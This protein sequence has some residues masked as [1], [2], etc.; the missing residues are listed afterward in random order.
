MI[1]AL[2]A[3]LLLVGCGDRSVATEPTGVQPT[4]SG[5]IGASVVSETVPLPVGQTRTLWVSGALKRKSRS[6]SQPTWRSS[7]P[8]VARVAAAT[9]GG[10][11]GVVTGVA[12][13]AAYVIARTPTAVDSFLVYVGTGPAALRFTVAG[14]SLTTGDTARVVVLDPKSSASYSSLNPTIASVSPTG[15]V[16]A[17]VA[18]Q[19]R[20]RVVDAFGAR[21]EVTVTVSS[22]VS[23]PPPVGGQRIAAQLTRFAAGSGT[24]LVSSGVPLPPAALRVSDLGT[25]RVLVGGTE[26][27][28]FVAA[29]QGRHVDGSV[30]TILVQFPYAV[31]QGTPVAAEI[32][33]GSS[34]TLADLPA[35]PLNPGLPD[36]VILPS[37]PNFLA[38]TNIVGPTLSVERTS[39]ISPLAAK[40]DVD[41]RPFADLLWNRYGDAWGENYYDRAQIYFAQWVRTGNPE[42]WLRGTRQALGYR[43]GYLEANSY[44]TSPHWSQVDGMALH[45]QLTGD[46]KSRFAVGRIAETL[47]YFRN[48]AGIAGTVDIESRILAR[49]LMAQLWGWRLQARGADA[50]ATSAEIS[51]LVTN[52][53]NLQSTD[54]AWRYPYVCA[55]SRAGLTYMDGMLSEALI[56]TYTYH[57][58]NPAI[59]SA[60]RKSTDYLWSKWDISKQAVAYA[61]D[62]ALN[63]PSQPGN[64]PYPELNN[65]LVN[66]FAWLYAQ[67]GDL[68]VRQKADSVFNGAVRGQ[69]LYGS[70]QF[71]QHYTTSYR[72]FF[73]R[74]AR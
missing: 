14:Y 26:Q 70:K 71:N 41:F 24:V 28:I 67:T 15:L 51:T 12:N 56:Q 35:Q 60:V 47:R 46:E 44:G 50:I 49:T 72:Y 66:S 55:T 58:A 40:Y 7:D 20:I 69:F 9:S 21:G 23:P 33:L 68:A 1:L 53:L 6:S 43:I 11:Y 30:M 19:A 5:E 3:G 27:P 13:G 38:S 54:G 32:V 36:A 57:A 42:Y 17:L 18:G 25:V 29:L 34:R 64:M 45:Y 22:V 65:L 8:G 4:L 2:S 39:A 16:T 48:R 63:D 62:C 61:P 73:W 59:L 74:S 10:Q 52:I 31:S 37:D